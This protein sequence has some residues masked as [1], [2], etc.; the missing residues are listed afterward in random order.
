MPIILDNIYRFVIDR[1]DCKDAKA[2]ARQPS[3]H[4]AAKS[5]HAAGMD[6]GV[7]LEL[8]NSSGYIY[9]GRTLVEWRNNQGD[10]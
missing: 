7:F 3:G 4:K 9:M 8:G 10:R 1:L 5:L 6:A 2:P